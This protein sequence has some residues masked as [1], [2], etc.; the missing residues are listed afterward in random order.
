MAN[1]ILNPPTEFNE[2]DAAQDYGRIVPLE[3]RE[4]L[5]ELKKMALE[6]GIARAV[7]VA[8]KLGDPF[9]LDELHDAL[10]DELKQRLIIEGKLEKL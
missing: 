5:E 3:K 10:T 7:F 1:E 6:K 9:L 4:K 8:K 2:Q